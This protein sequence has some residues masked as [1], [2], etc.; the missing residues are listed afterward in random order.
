V[1]V[2]DIFYEVRKNPSG[3]AFTVAP[4]L[5]RE[6]IFVGA[7]A[8]GRPCLFVRADKTLSEPPLRTTHISLQLSREYTLAIGGGSPNR[9]LFHSL[10]CESSGSPDVDT[11]LV[12]IDAFL[13]RHE[14]QSVVADTLSSFFRS[15]VR[16]FAVT[17]VRDL[18][19]ERQGLWGELFMMS[20]V[21]GFRFWAPFWHTEPTRRFD[22]SAPGRR[23]EV[24]TTMG[25]ERI[26]HFSHHQIYSHEEEEIVIASLLLKEEEEGQSLR[27]LIDGCRLALQDT[28]F[29]LRLEKAIRQ[30]GMEASSETGPIFDAN[31]A[32]R[33]LAW[34]KSTDAPHFRV[35]EPAGV[36]ETRYKVDLSTAP[37]LDSGELEDWLNSWFQASLS[38]TG[39]RSEW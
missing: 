11:F 23:V 13:A 36:S 6:G 29:Y 10:C 34:F 21:Q 32:E 31:E 24:K 27:Q 17:P 1:S 22:F 20:C 7:D 28:P 15:L 38:V 2:A 4:V 25:T 19:A 30:A 12:L 8:D 5:H 3:H 35:P 39:S 18:E 16:L 9:E 26:H 14:G 37:R 33:N